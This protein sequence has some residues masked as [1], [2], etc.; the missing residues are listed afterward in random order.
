MVEDGFVL[1]IDNEGKNLGKMSRRDAQS[2]AHQRGLD[3]VDVGGK[4]NA[5]VCKIMDK[6]KFAYSQSKN[7]KKPTRKG[8]MVKEIKFNLRIGPHDQDIKIE[9][10]KKFLQ[11]GFSVRIYVIMK[12]REKGRISD[13]VNKAQDILDSLG[14]LAKHDSIK[15]SNSQVTVMVHSSL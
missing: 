11:K 10:I 8:K 7:Q 14:D 5:K 15:S 2:I 1:V 9:H 3:L 12:G 4:S 6:G 13:G